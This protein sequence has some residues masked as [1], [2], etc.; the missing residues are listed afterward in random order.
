M[1]GLFLRRRPLSRRFL[2][3]RSGSAVAAPLFEKVLVA[4]RGE[5]ALRVMR[6]CRRLGIRTVAV[7]S[8]ADA[9]S[10]HVRCADEAVCI[11]PSSSTDSYLRI[12]R[13]LA[14]ARQTGV[15]AIHPGYGFLSENPNFAD[16]VEAAGL[17]FVG[18]SSSAMLA[19]GDKINSKKIAQSAGCFIIP[20]FN[21]EITNAE[22]ARA[23][24]RDIGY[25]VM[26]KASAGGG[27][28]GMRVAYDDDQLSELFQLCKDEA[29]SSFGDGRLLVEKF[30]EEPH[31]IEIQVLA[32]SFGN[33]IAFPEREVSMLWSIFGVSREP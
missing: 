9:R 2:P 30:I 28:K 22:E 5:I 16:A 20:G 19:M 12:D 15:Q 25:P 26:V 3:R 23:V 6:T 11:G 27:G 24:V 18:P 4:N 31:H 8:E 33:V 13:I 32:D 21:G 14:A 10:L 1:L 7:F 17:V 29:Q